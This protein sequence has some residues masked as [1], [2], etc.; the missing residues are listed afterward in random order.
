MPLFRQGSANKTKDNIRIESNKSVR[1][2]FT[3]SILR[4]GDQEAQA[5]KGRS[6][7]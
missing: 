3:G 5:K 2:I 7:K 1:K 4:L 6:Q